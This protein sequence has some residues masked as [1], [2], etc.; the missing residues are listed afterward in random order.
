MV[1]TA[2]FEK[3]DK[4]MEFAMAR[5]DSID[6]AVDDQNKTFD[7]MASAVGQYG[8]GQVGDWLQTIK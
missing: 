7:T 4:M 6:K 2:E 8:L 1:E 3:Q 5:K